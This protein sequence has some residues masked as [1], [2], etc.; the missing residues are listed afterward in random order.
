[1]SHKQQEILTTD[2]QLSHENLTYTAT[3]AGGPRL[4]T[5]DP[6]TGS[7][8][9]LLEAMRQPGAE[10]IVSKRDGSPYRG[11]TG[12]DW[13]K[14][15]V[16]EEGAFVVTGYIEREAVAVAGFATSLGLHP[17]DVAHPA[18]FSSC[19]PRRNEEW[20]EIVG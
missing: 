15:K 20:I 2:L 17:P 12:C 8:A 13:L 18:T 5:V 7:G 19:L 1:M 10:G 16:S 4:V 11:G 3:R 9:V 14:T 6:F